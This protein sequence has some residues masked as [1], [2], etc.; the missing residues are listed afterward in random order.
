M[1]ALPVALAAVLAAVQLATPVSGQVTNASELQVL[2]TCPDA[3]YVGRGMA[4]HAAWLPSPQNARHRRTKVVFI[5][6][7]PRIARGIGGNRG[8][9]VLLTDQRQGSLLDGLP[10]HLPELPPLHC[11]PPSLC[12]YLAVH[13]QGTAM[14]TSPPALQPNAAIHPPYH[15]LHASSTPIAQHAFNLH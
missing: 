1:T 13:D 8:L 9:A 7:R 3:I 5:T 12:L 15:W 4:L 10:A 14:L 11:P 2:V 6:S